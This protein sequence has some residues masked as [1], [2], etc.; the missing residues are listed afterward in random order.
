MYR[1]EEELVR[2][3]IRT[4]SLEHEQKGSRTLIEVC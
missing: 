3:R 4:K 2:V 1:N